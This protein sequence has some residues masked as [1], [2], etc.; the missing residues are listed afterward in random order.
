MAKYYPDG[1]LLKA[2]PAKGSSFTWR[3][4]W[5]VYK[6]LNMLIFEEWVQAPRLILG[7]T[8]GFLT[9]LLGKL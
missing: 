2:G 4:L 7:R 6:H 9:T 8:I 1:D 3:V 5:L